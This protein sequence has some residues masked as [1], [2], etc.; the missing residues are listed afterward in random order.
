MLM[1]GPRSRLGDPPHLWGGEMATRAG[2]AA[3]PGVS[4][5]RDADQAR[6]APGRALDACT[7]SQYDRVQPQARCFGPSVSACLFRP[8]CFGPLFT[9][10]AHD[11]SP[12]TPC[13]T[14]RR[15]APQALLPTWALFAA[16]TSTK[17]EQVRTLTVGGSAANVGAAAAAAAAAAAGEVRDAGHGAHATEL[18]AHWHRQAMAPSLAP[19]R[20]RRRAP[21]APCASPGWGLIPR[22]TVATRRLGSHKSHAP[23]MMEDDSDLPPSKAS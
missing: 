21:H 6:H 14:R 16:S 3:P 23:W 17:H 9:P 15:P 13:Q 4:A 1:H 5:V 8:V 7:R 11:R 22:V 12:S 2:E 19:H 18:V 20:S 10:L